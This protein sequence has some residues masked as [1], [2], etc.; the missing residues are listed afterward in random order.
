MEALTPNQFLPGKKEYLL[1]VPAMSR[2]I[3]VT[4]ENSLRTQAYANLICDM[5]RKKFWPKLNVWPKW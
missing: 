3:F 2:E 1:T 5:Y 4:I